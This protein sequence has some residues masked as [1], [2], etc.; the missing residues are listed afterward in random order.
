MELIVN[1]AQVYAYTGG[2]P[3]NPELPAVV[4]IHGAEN[5][6]SVWGLQSRWF[7]HH[8]FCVLAVDLPGHGRSA[9]PLLASVEA[10]ADWIVALLDAAGVQEATLVGHSM[11]SLAALETASRYRERVTRIALVGTA[12]PMPVSEALL[13]AAREARPRAE[14]MVNVWSHGPRGAIG[15]NTVPGMWLMGASLR[16]MER[17]APEVLHNDLNACNAYAR[18]TE[19]AAA[20]TCP[21]LLVVGSRDLMTSPRGAPK[22]AAAMKDARIATIEGSGHALMA[23]YPDAVLDALRSFTQ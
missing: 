11:G 4:F 17:A 5:D 6:H 10:L 13:T 12:V 19:A 18:G 22:L 9:G 2:K 20:A 23:E 3:F 14:G 8:G 7:A 15:G 21:A 1:N 16:L